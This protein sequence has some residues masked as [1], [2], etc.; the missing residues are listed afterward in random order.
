HFERKI[1]NGYIETISSGANQIKD[2]DLHKYYDKL[3]LV[4]KGKL[5]DMNRLKEIW[6]FN[7]GKYNYLLANYERNKNR[8][9]DSLST[10]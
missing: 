9:Q 1:P 7:L 6:N 8:L 2:P 5:W 3:S 10:N 4:I